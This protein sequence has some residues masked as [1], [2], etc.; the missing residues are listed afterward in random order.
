[1]EINKEQKEIWI[2]A[3]ACAV[4]IALF[5]FLVF[6]FV[7]VRVF[8]GIILISL[9]FYFILSNFDL[10]EPEKLVFSMLLGF[11][12]FSG[13]VYWLGF[14]LPFK[15][16]IIAMFIILAVISFVIKKFKSKKQEKQ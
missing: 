15:F 6:G 8:A 16:S 14:L 1:M 12:L 3:A 13:L 4:V 9:P 5:L 10:S 7:G 2:F 11:V